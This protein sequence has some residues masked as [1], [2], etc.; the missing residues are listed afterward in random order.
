MIRRLGQPIARGRTADI[1]A[2]EPDQI[3]KL[4]HADRS[5]ASAE[6]EA[7]ISRLVH[8]SGLAIPAV[9]EIIE[10]HGRYG[11]TYERIEGAS[12]LTD[13]VARP[14]T[15]MRAALTLAELHT[16]IHD[17]HGADLPT[18]RQRLEK[19]IR[20]AAS[21]PSSVEAQL[22]DSLS[23]L[24]DER[25]LLHGDF[26]PDNVLLTTRG[27]IIIDWNDATVGDPWADV[28]R[29]S[30][31]LTASQLP[32]DAPGRLFISAGRRW[33]H[34][35]YLK[36]YTKLRPEGRAR[37]ARWQ[38]IVAAARLAE[39]IPGERDRLMALIMSPSPASS[40]RA[41]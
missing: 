5:L 12:L 8:A 17:H 4:F 10:T 40:L 38:P 15:L 26:H 18:I 33:L 25:S 36:R 34:R 28:A 16:T 3:L 13:L 24:H 19:N 30:L 27:P 22:L 21:L 41:P 37:L 29:T 32:P 20:S 14:W 39:N 9:G 35:V 2:W 31:L 7:R 11:L 23:T 1:F 6:Y